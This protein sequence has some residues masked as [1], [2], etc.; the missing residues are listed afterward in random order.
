MKRKYPFMLIDTQMNTIAIGNEFENVV[1]EITG[2][3]SIDT[4]RIYLHPNRQ[5]LYRQI[6]MWLNG[7]MEDE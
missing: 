2:L 5:T 1:A 6:S 4:N 3:K 7:E